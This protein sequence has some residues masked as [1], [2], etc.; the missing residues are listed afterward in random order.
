MKLRRRCERFNMLLG[1]QR[2]ARLQSYKRPKF[3]SAEDEA[4][5]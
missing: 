2:G 5:R 3:V 1:G 4:V